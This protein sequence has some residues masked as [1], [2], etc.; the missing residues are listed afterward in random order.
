MWDWYTV[1]YL[2]GRL[3]T[4]SAIC[5]GTRLR[6]KSHLRVYMLVTAIRPAVRA[7][8]HSEACVMFTT[9]P[10][11]LDKA[12]LGSKFEPRVHLSNYDINAS[13]KNAE[14][15]LWQHVTVCGWVSTP[16]VGN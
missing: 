14:V 12:K 8:V 13:P 3:N 4:V 9:M 1:R 16:M 7:Y 6:Y 10:Y 2:V 11:T 5:T 15:H